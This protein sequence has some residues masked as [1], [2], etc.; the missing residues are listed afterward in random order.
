VNAWYE[1]R[2]GRPADLGRRVSM[3]PSCRGE[4]VAALPGNRISC[5]RQDVQDPKVD[6]GTAP[7]AHCRADQ[8]GSGTCA[9]Y[10]KQLLVLPITHGDIV[11]DNFSSEI[12]RPFD[13]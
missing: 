4:M 6:A 8:P 10:V 7:G 11:M 12:R 3:W 1:H 5:A 13:G 9:P 2:G